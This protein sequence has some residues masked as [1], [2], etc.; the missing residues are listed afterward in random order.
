MYRIQQTRKNSIK[1]EAAMQYLILAVLLCW[2]FLAC[3]R[4]RHDPG[5]YRRY[6]WALGLLIATAMLVQ[7]G[8][9]LLSGLLDW[10]N[11]LPLHLCSL[12][13][14]LTLPT[15]LG[16]SRML[17]SAALLLGSPG[18]LLALVFPS[19]LATPW[20]FATALAFHTLHAGLLCEPWLMISGGWQPVPA[21]AARAGGFLLLAG[22]AAMIV[23]PVSG[24][25]YLFL[26]YPI[27]GT[28]LAWLGRWGIWPYRGMLTAAALS[29][30]GAESL[31]L[32]RLQ[33]RSAR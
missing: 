22:L 2:T 14:V 29:A 4:I 11:G 15:L 8:V 6:A 19:I 5:L 23:N 33:K 16:D 7:E 28:P 21:D 25:N 1:K 26:A 17:R 31:L 30:L 12:L 24:G 9:L 18:A 13:G 20:P 32:C 3:R 27:A 10:S